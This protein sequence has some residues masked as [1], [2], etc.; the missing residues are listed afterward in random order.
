MKKTI[1]QV[2]ATAMI[3]LCVACQNNK[4]KQLEHEGFSISGAVTGFPNGTKIYLRNLATD[5]VFDSTVVDNN[6][7]KFNGELISPPE[8]IWITAIVDDQFIYT[9]L[10]IE[11]DDITVQGDITD[12]PWDVKITG[13]KTQDDFNYIRNKTKANDIKRDSLTNAYIS[14]SFDEREK[15]FKKI[16]G[17]INTIDSVNKLITL[18]YIK[19]HSDTYASIIKLNAY[20]GSFEKEEVQELFDG[21]DTEI[22]ESKYGR[23]IEVFLKEKISEIGDQFHDFEGLNQKQETVVF[24]EIRGKFTL[25]N[26]T[27]AYCG[28]CIQSIDELKEIQTTFSDSLTIVSFSGDPKKEYWLQALK[29]DETD[30]LSIWDGKG[31]YSETSIKYGIQGF[32]TFVLIN[33]DGTIIKKWSGYG[34]VGNLTKLIEKY[35]VL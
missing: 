4:E 6:Q 32:P 29:R 12:F 35:V 25:L 31:R 20:K 16:W 24:S 10:L 18:K 15:Q 27:S 34:K 9:N 28:P 19:D 13:S 22:K 33:P 7:F 3:L 23:V 8:Q 30:W 5:A 11:N 21:Y 14:L 2:I 26:F 1:N 17:P